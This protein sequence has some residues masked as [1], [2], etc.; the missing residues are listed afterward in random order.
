MLLYMH[1]NGEQTLLTIT[2]RDWTVMLKPCVLSKHFRTP[3][4]IVKTLVV[5]NTLSLSDPLYFLT[6]SKDEGVYC[7]YM[8]STS[9]KFMER[10]K[11]ICFYKLESIL[12]NLSKLIKLETHKKLGIFF[13]L[14][15]QQLL[16]IFCIQLLQY[17]KQKM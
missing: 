7:E 14:L 16:C 5:Q 10:L 11:Y 2:I 17:N 8:K 6:N 13:L 1:P 3:Q 9:G 15:I 12:F 4:C